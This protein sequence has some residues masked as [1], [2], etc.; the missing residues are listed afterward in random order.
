MH[1]RQ[2]QLFFLSSYGHLGPVR[3]AVFST[4]GNTILTGSFD[5]T[6]RL[7]R[8]TPNRWTLEDMERVACLQAGKRVDQAGGLRLVIPDDLEAL[9]EDLNKQR[10]DLFVTPAG[11]I[12]AWHKRQAAA[13]EASENWGAARFHIER[14]WASD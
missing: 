8:L 10:P 4:N 9:W 12:K 3:S 13:A 14:G 11:R 5:R 7:W 2:R 1:F 6:V